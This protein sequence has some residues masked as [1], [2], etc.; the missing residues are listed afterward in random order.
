MFG[1]SALLHRIHVRPGVQAWLERLDY[2]AIFVFIAA[3][4]TPFALL[5]GEQGLVLLALVWGSA[6]L[7]VLRAFF[8]VNAPHFVAVALYLAVGWLAVLFAK[9]L[10]VAV[11]AGGFAWLIGGGLLYSAG[12]VVFALKRPNPRPRVFGFHEVFHALV[13]VACLCQLVPIADAVARLR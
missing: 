7:G 2:S 11:G 9:P 6:G 10:W 12:A 5:L 1:A 13:I 4:Y 8:W 3:S